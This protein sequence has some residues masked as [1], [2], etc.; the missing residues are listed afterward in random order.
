[1]DLPAATRPTTVPSVTRVPP[2]T[3]SHRPHRRNGRL[4]PSLGSPV[5]RARWPIRARPVSTLSG[6]GQ[7]GVSVYLVGD[8]A[9]HI[10]GQVVTDAG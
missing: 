6:A 10:L 5:K 8:A 7:V 3:A 2:S 9:P 4:G 1:M